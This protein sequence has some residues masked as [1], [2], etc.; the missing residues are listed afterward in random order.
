MVDTRPGFIIGGVFLLETATQTTSIPT[1]TTM[2]VALTG[3]MMLRSIHSGKPGKLDLVSAS[4][5][6]PPKGGAR[7]PSMEKHTFS[8]GIIAAF[9]DTD[10][11][12]GNDDDCKSGHNRDDEVEVCEEGHDLTLQISRSGQN[13]VVGKLSGGGQCSWKHRC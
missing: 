11:N 10:N 7:V 9:D 13:V 8:D 1:H 5:I 12:D 4:L 2:M 6:L 3:T